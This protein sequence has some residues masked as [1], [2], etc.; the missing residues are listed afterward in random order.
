M[1]RTGADSNPPGSFSFRST[2]KQV[3]KCLPFS[4]CQARPFNRYHRR[5]RTGDSIQNRQHAGHRLIDPSDG[6]NVPL[7][8]IEQTPELTGKIGWGNHDGTV[9]E[10]TSRVNNDEESTFAT[11]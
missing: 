10:K 2:P 3:P 9:N 1:H 8:I 7:P 11:K 5:R 6:F 4:P